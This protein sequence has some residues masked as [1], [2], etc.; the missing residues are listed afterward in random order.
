MS[1]EE[2]DCTSDIMIQGMAPKPKEN[3]ITNAWQRKKKMSASLNE[4]LSARRKL[5]IHSVLK[6]TTSPASESILI[7]EYK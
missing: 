4:L 1:N 7:A 3:E 5:N 6:L 2:A